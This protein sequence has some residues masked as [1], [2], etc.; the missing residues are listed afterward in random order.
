[1]EADNRINIRVYKRLPG[2]TILIWNTDL[3]N[4]EQREHSQVRIKRM[5]DQSWVVPRTASS[6]DLG[7]VMTDTDTDSVA[8]MHNEDLSEDTPFIAKIMFGRM[9]IREA[10]V[11]VAGRNS[12]MPFIKPIRTDGGVYAMPVHLINV[13]ELKD[14]IVSDI[15][16][17][18]KGKDNEKG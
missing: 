12:H 13:T 1:M 15:K 16:N 5:T 8:I 14:A 6:R 11:K 7:V 3:L 9:E 10:A 4:Q 18:L 2:G 17:L